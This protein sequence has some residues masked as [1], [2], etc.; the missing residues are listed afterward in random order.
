VHF[1]PLK[2]FKK[3]KSDHLDFIHDIAYDFY[4]KRLAT[5]SSDKLIKIWDQNNVGEWKCSAEI[6]GAG[7]V[8]KLSWAHPEF[9][10]VLAACSS[11]RVVNIYEEQVNSKTNQRTWKKQGRLVDSRDSVQC[12]QFLPRPGVLKLAASSL[13]GKVRIYEAT[14]VMNLS[15]WNLVEEFDAAKKDVYCLS[16]NPS[17]FDN[18]MMVVGAESTARVWEYF[19][20][21]FKWQPVADLEGHSDTVHDVS[22]APNMGRTYHLLATACKDGLVRIYKL[23]LQQTKSGKYEVE[24]VAKLPQHK[25]EVWRV[26][27]NVTGTMLASSGDDG[28]ARLWKADFKG[29]WHQVT[30]A[31]PSGAA[32]ADPA[33][34]HKGQGGKDDSMDHKQ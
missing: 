32:A 14:D 22:W 11:D 5:C 19:P 27:W 17:P 24:L 34:D 6:K 13:D 23:K 4:G 3:F 20:K 1:Q 15:V 26:S 18:A 28:V 8:N 12:V 31:T 33:A 7:A 29:Q 16:W 25:S 30:S 2:A 21:A 9:G 10:T